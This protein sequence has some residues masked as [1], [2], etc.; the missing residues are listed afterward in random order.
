[1][2]GEANDLFIIISATLC[3]VWPVICYTQ[4]IEGPGPLGQACQNTLSLL[5]SVLFRR[6]LLT[7]Q[8]T[9]G[10][11]RRCFEQRNTVPLRKLGFVVDKLAYSTF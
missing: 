1:M 10:Y 11:R 2:G 4:V 5:T 8:V 9:L 3:S 7:S 6:Y